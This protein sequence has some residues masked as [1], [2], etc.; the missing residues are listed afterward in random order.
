MLENENIV[1]FNVRLYD[2]A[3]NS[4]ALGEKMLEEKLGRKIMKYLLKTF[5]L[6]V[7]VIEEAQ[8]IFTMKVVEFYYSLLTLEMAIND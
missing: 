5:D 1:E 2:I 8:E 7:T 6:K 4:F 3:N